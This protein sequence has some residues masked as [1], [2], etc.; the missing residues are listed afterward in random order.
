MFRLM[1]GMML[2]MSPC[3]LAQ[4]TQPA[5]A[6]TKINVYNVADL[7]RVK[8][9]YP[10]PHSGLTPHSEDE[11]FCGLIGG[12]HDAAPDVFSS[13]VFNVKEDETKVERVMQLITDSVDP[14]SWKANGGLVGN[15]QEFDGAFVVEQTPANHEKIGQL[16]KSLR[17][18][19]S[20]G[21][22]VRVRAYWM[23]LDQDHADALLRDGEEPTTTAPVDDALADGDLYAVGEITCLNRQA[24]H[25]LSGRERT[26]TADIDP[27]VSTDAVGLELT[28]K[29]AFS[30]VELLVRPELS[31]D[32]KSVMVDVS[33]TMTESEPRTP[34]AVRQVRTA[35]SQ[36]TL[37]EL[38][39][40]DQLKQQFQTT[41]QLPVGRKVLVGGMTIEPSKLNGQ[42]LYLV[43]EVSEVTDR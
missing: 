28:Q 31:E 40:V 20:P 11:G 2:S 34:A 10:S 23:A 17:A 16:L 38:D 26:V 33:S 4:T 32:R 24:V 13:R 30:G 42:Q 15:I 25:L 18:T 3:A 22:T 5:E 7:V 6:E 19:L 27:V 29:I 8:S 14:M 43:L 21:T 39:Q 1:L 35:T 37:A 12:P 36:P 9:D 41:V